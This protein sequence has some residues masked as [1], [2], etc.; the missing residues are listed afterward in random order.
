MFAT[1]IWNPYNSK[2]TGQDFLI[3]ATGVTA[4][5]VYSLWTGMA[6]THFDPRAPYRAA[7]P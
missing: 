4:L 7:A 1:P 2:D 6:V 3:A 5:L